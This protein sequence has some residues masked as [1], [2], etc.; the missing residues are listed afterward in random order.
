M[1]AIIRELAGYA[2]ADDPAVFAQD[3]S[4]LMEGAYVTRPVTRNPDAAG[5]AR[6]T[7]NMLVEKH[8]PAAR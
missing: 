4:L 8:L 2:G 5:I 7:I 6:R 3:M 1:G